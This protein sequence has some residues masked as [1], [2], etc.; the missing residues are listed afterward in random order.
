MLYLAVTVQY[1]RGG[2]ERDTHTIYLSF[3]DDESE[4]NSKIESAMHMKSFFVFGGDTTFVHK[5]ILSVAL[6]SKQT[7]FR[8]NARFGKAMCETF[9]PIN[10]YADSLDPDA[11]SEEEINDLMQRFGSLGGDENEHYN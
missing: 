10:L 7:Y 2:M 8:H 5:E 3:S 6:I 9:D 1:S 11:Y 4:I